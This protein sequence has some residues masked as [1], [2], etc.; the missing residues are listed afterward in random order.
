MDHGK[1]SSFDVQNVLRLIVIAEDLTN[2]SLFVLKLEWSFQQRLQFI[3]D[4]GDS[5]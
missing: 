5:M 3:G 2:F 1:N 4:W